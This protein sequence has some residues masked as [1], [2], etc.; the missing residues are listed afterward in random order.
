MISSQQQTAEEKEWLVS[1]IRRLKKE[2]NMVVLAHYYQHG[3]V[4]DI[5]DYV[6]DSLGLS[7]AAQRTE[8]RSILFAG[9]RFMAETAKI[10][11]PECTVLLPD[12]AAGCSLADACPPESFK[13][14]IQDYPGHVVVSYINCSAEVKAMSDM[15]CTSAN[16]E[17]V[18]AS[19]PKEN[20]IIFAPD[21]NLGKYLIAKT[22]RDMVLW[23]GSCVV[24]EA[25]SIDKLLT[26]A[27]QYPNAK[28]LA[29]PESPAHILRVAHFIGSTT[30]M[31]RFA[32]NDS[33]DQFIVATEAG[34]LHEMS[35]EIPGTLIIPA[36]AHENNTCACSECGFMKMTTL[37]KVYRCML[38]EYPVINVD[39]RIRLRAL[40]PIMR[41]LSISEN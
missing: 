1:E 13:E 14:F 41:M 24:H 22:G 38:D 27:R 28:I 21:K 37:E 12:L 39:E 2:K 15:I 34:I 7:L 3:E 32:K 29:H 20:P 18:I 17:K 4:Q 33:G 9:V 5:A 8:A 23:E 11:N 19:I 26:L 35:G 40:E 10:I 6:G 16:A 30:A 31:I 25:F 36:P